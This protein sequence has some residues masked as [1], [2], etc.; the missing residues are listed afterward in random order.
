MLFNFG[1]L[2]QFCKNLQGADS[3]PGNHIQDDI[4]SPHIKKTFAKR[5][6][7]ESGSI[8]LLNDPIG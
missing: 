8:R 3:V 6:T 2:F 4:L 1:I 5:L 7:K